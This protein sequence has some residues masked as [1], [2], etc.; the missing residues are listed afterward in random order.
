MAMIH[1]DLNPTPRKIREFGIVSPIMLGLIGLLLAWRFGLSP[2]WPIALGA[3]GIALFLLSRMAPVCVRPVYQGL[4][5][6]GFP[7]GWV[8]SHVVMLLFFFAVLT[9]IALLFR[10]VG[11]DVLSRKWDDE[12][13]SYWTEYSRDDR[14]QRYFRQF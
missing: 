5:L 8:V 9:P 11:R 7:I 1:L 4:V 14:V 3:V 2:A 12:C 10:L 6:V 13:K